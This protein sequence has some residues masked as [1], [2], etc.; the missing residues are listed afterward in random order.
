[1]GEPIW[2]VETFLGFDV[3]VE[4]LSD[5]LVARLTPPDCHALQRI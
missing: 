4:Q 5:R 2:L 3:F 1:V